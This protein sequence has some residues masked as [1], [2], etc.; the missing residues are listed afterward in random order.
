MVNSYFIFTYNPPV[1]KLAMATVAASEC[2]KC[3][4][5]MT[6]CVQCSACTSQFHFHC[7]GITEVG[8]RKLGDRKST[9]R[10]V[11]CKQSGVP[12]TSSAAASAASSQ[13]ADCMLQEIRALAVKLAPLESLAEDL[14]ALR[15][16]FAEMRS[17]LKE[18]NAKV[19]EFDKRLSNVEKMQSRFGEVETRLSKLEED[20]KS[21]E[22]WT[23]MNNVELKGV[24]EI[25]NE[26][27][28]D[29]VTKIGTKISYAIEKH[30]INFITRV[31]TR[32]AG[33]VKPIIVCFNNRYVKENFIAAARLANR[34]A[35]LAASSIGLKGA[36]RIYVND[37]LT[38]DNKNLLSKVKLK[39]KELGFQ[40][41][42]VKHAKIHARRGDGSPI[43]LI[44]TEQDLK[45]II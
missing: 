40:Y 33:H 13:S 8:Y 31:Q 4:D 2:F 45:K 43:I 38:T 35:P 3:G 37:H 34:E 20:A 41:V 42:W 12:C 30:Q 19:T 6:D 18:F 7:A 44:R 32:N 10:C 39:A 27:L 11:P 36:S 23:R 28:Y 5:T 29:V 1:L 26:N 17:S 15:S 16:E 25:R 14:K 21:K 9:W 22:Q 24:P